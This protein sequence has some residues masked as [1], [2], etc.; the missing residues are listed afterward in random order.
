MN[1]PYGAG[2]RERLDLFFPPHINQPTPIHLFVHGGYWRSG[3]RED[4]A[5]VA[6]TIIRAGAI[7]AL[8]EY[9]LVPRARPADQ[10]ASLRRAAAWLAA[11]A[12]SFGGDADQI[13]ASGHS[14]GATLCCFLTARSEGE[15][16]TG[17]PP[18]RAMVL[19]SGIYDLAPIAQSFLQAEL[20]LTPDEIRRWSPLTARCDPA[21]RV[22]L[23]VGQ[24][25]TAPFHEQQTAFAISLATQGSRAEVHMLPGLDHM[26][27]VR[28]LGRP[29]TR[30]AALIAHAIADS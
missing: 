27:I 30:A 3:A 14:A 15:T 4:Y 9:E 22:V 2:S 7:A 19:A 12:A 17:G 6:E 1:V 13:S 24:R 5:F 26:S 29:G 16:S 28:E 21:T 18:L 11:N 25:E 10:I 8:L 23:A 20:Q